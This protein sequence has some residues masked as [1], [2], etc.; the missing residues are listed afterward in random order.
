MKIKLFIL[1][2][3]SNELF[4]FFTPQDMMDRMT[5]KNA[6]NMMLMPLHP[7]KKIAQGIRLMEEMGTLTEYS[8]AQATRNSARSIKKENGTI[9][10]IEF[11]LY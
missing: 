9:P 10:T 2:A 5:L 6:K 8:I 1:L 3:L 4:A 7:E 11:S